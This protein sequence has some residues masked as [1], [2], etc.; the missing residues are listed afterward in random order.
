M[1]IRIRR[2]GSSKA[3][4]ATSA[5]TEPTSSSGAGVKPVDRLRLLKVEQE[6]LKLAKLRGELVE[7][8]MVQAAWTHRLQLVREALLSLRFKLPPLLINLDERQMSDVIDKEVR[9][10]MARYS[11]GEAGGALEGDG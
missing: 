6:E 3:T 8:E 1:G 5:E 7:R 11:A 10:L 4:T 9:E 2:R